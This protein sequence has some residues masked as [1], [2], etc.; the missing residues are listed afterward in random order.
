MLTSVCCSLLLLTTHCSLLTTHC[1]LLT[2]TP[3]SSFLIPHSSFLIPHCSLL[4][5]H[6]YY[7]LL[8]THYSLLTTHHS[9]LTTHYS[10]LTHECLLLTS[11]QGQSSLSYNSPLPLQTTRAV[12]HRLDCHYCRSRSQLCISFSC[13][14]SSCCCRQFNASRSP[15]S[16]HCSHY[17]LPDSHCVLTTTHKILLP[18]THCSQAVRLEM[19]PTI[20]LPAAFF[21]PAVVV[22]MQRRLAVAQGVGSNSECAV[23]CERIDRADGIVVL[24]SCS[25]AFHSECIAM[26]I[27]YNQTCPLCRG[28]AV[29][30][31]LVV[32]PC[33]D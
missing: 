13:C 10:L 28:P 7:S 30:S 29:C 3:H 5:A 6:C 21:C 16:P 27:S 9:L 17:P 8:T 31:Q 14:R 4:T 12:S 22:E 18:T 19:L 2:A 33:L 25:H 23:C 15:L 32:V 11:L 26:W 20:G 24:P 1:S